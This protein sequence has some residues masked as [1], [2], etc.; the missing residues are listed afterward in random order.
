MTELEHRLDVAVCPGCGCVYSRA[1][2]ARHLR[3][4]RYFACPACRYEYNNPGSPRPLTIGEMAAG[5]TE[6]L[7]DGVN[8]PALVCAV[9]QIVGGEPA[10]SLP[11]VEE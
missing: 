3:A 8:V 5:K 6:G 10:A 9:L 4:R 1:D 2:L 11:T 7:S